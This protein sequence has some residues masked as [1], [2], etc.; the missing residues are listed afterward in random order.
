VVE[1]FAA[2]IRFASFAAGLLLL[3]IAAFLTEDEESGLQNRLENWWIALDDRRSASL[4]RQAAF[5]QAIAALSSRGF[6]QVFGSRLI[7][8]Q[9]FAVSCAFSIA[10][11]FAYLTVKQ[12]LILFENPGW[13]P[14]IIW[15]ARAAPDWRVFPLYVALSLAFLVVPILVKRRVPERSHRAVYWATIALSV[16]ISA[17]LAFLTA[18]APYEFGSTLEASTEVL[19]ST[20]TAMMPTEEED[21]V[22]SFVQVFIP[23]ALIAIVLSFAADLI[24]VAFT[25]IVLRSASH[26]A[27][28]FRIVNL[29]AINL[30]L[31][32][33]LLALPQ[34]VGDYWWQSPSSGDD[35][36]SWLGLLRLFGIF[37]KMFAAT[38][39][40]D[41]FIALIFILISL[42]ML[43][44]VLVWPLLQRPVYALQR[45]GIVKRRA[46][47]VSVSLVFLSLATGGV[48]QLLQKASEALTK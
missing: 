26:E 11:L 32:M 44:H 4:S 48:N 3:Y 40:L 12:L 35:D 18:I 7:S 33:L 37:L 8:L 45:L 15:P 29:I 34:A 13:V 42:L 9:A 28:P 23:L 14:E 17:P 41:A 47:L 25:R 43:T 24:F 19:L 27:R 20:H 21:A 1:Y 22:G 46:F 16:W 6:D 38:N 36:N 31:A 30:A 10:S 5:L 2:L 39:G